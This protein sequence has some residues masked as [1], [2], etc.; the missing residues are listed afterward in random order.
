MGEVLGEAADDGDEVVWLGVD[1]DVSACGVEVRVL[2]VYFELFEEGVVE[3]FADGGVQKPRTPGLARPGVRITSKWRRKRD[4][5]FDD[6]LAMLFH[7]RLNSIKSKIVT[8][9]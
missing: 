7:H 1:D 8:E 5:R 9:F 6:R 4:E 2:C 3:Q